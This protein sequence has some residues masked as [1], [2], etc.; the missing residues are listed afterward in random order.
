MV[1]T[2][3]G[4]YICIGSVPPHE[5]VSPDDE[6]VI[7]EDNLVKQ[8]AREGVDDPNIAVLVRGLGKTYPG[9]TN[10]GFC[11]CKKNS[12]YQAL[13]VNIDIYLL[14]SPSIHGTATG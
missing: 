3:G 6:D 12:P 11:K 13:K 7:E 14:Y 8:Q 1:F 9:S 2:E 4:I 5:D 10:I